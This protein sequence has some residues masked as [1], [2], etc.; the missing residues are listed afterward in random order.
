MIEIIEADKQLLNDFINFPFTLYPKKSF[1]VPPLISEEKKLLSKKNPF[2]KNNS[3]KLYLAKQ[4]GKYVGRIAGI[5]NKEHNNYYNDK[6]GFF[7]FFESIN[8]ID[9]SKLL[10]SSAS[11]FLKE[12]GLN[13]MRGPVNPSMNDTCGVLIEGFYQPPAFMMPYNFPYYDSLLKNSGLSK[14]MDLYAWYL[15]LLAQISRLE[16]L[17]QKIIK[18]ENLTIRNLSM[19]NFKR[20]VKIIWELYCQAWKDNWGFV[21]PTEE[22]FFYGIQ[23]LKNIGNENFIFFIE[24]KGS[25]VAFSAFLP[26]FN[27]LL[28]KLNGTLH[29]WQ[30][31]SFLR[32]IKKI[33]SARLAVLGIK[34]SYQGRG[35]DLI[36]YVE[37][38]KTAKKYGMSGGE[39]GWTLESNIK[40]NGGIKKMG[41]ELYKRYR[42]YDKQ[43]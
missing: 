4:D 1:W 3:Y 14:A 29:F 12:N 35:L 34:E 30:I 15:T 7:G 6:T 41:S 39:M 42:L 19:K 17:E 37:S 33:S 11:N 27:Q 36:L 5:I 22:E 9:V 31:P 28:K 23:D 18:R 21:P 20:D 8:N 40:I 25:P 26:D 38:F 10:F 16:K 13:K 2:W 32:A 24:D 43:L